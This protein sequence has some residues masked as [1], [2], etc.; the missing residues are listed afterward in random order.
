MQTYKMFYICFIL[1]FYI[2]NIRSIDH[3]SG[4]MKANKK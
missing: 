2:V 3:I 4:S 1:K